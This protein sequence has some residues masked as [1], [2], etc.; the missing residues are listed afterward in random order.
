[1]GEDRGQGPHQMVSGFARRNGFKMVSKK[2]F[3]VVR[4]R[5]TTVSNV[6]KF[7]DV[8]FAAAVGLGAAEALPYVTLDREGAS[9]LRFFQP[10]VVGE[11]GRNVRIAFSRGDA[12]ERTGHHQVRGPEKDFS[13]REVRRTATCTCRR[14]WK[15]RIAPTFC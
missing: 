15:C 1:M 10:Q 3:D 11:N 7:Y 9:Q 5:W 14:S 13:G 12:R 6:S 2:D 8:L 4:A